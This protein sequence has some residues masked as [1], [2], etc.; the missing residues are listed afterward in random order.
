MI[1][2]LDETGYLSDDHAE[3]FPNLRIGTFVDDDA[4]GGNSTVG[5]SRVAVDISAVGS[6]VGVSSVE[7]FQQAFRG[8]A[9][10]HWLVRV[11]EVSRL[12]YS[13][14]ALCAT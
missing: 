9:R 8:D 4:H 1:G 3:Y 6:D 5:V 2:R 13:A 12:R 10:V 11:V 14:Q 7:L